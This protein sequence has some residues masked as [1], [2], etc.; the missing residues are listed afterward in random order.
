MPNC[1]VI[2]LL[3]CCRE[4]IQIQSNTRGRGDDVADIDTGGYLL[5]DAKTDF[6]YIV[7]YGC[8]PSDGTP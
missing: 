5:E 3:D 8:P 4:L 2:A 7:T 6:N 1:Y